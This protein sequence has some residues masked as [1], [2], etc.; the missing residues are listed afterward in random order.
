MRGKSEHRELRDEA[1]YEA[2]KKT[3]GDFPMLSFDEQ[4]QK[5][6]SARQPRMWVSFYGVY[7]MLLRIIAEKKTHYKKPLRAG[8]EKEIEM[9]YRRLQTSPYMKNASAY[10]IAS[11]IIAEPS[12]GFYVSHSYAKRIIFKTIHKKQQERHAT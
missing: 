11:F 5:T 4:I 6:L 12:A 7:R 8:L 2:Y 9:K 1:L 10:F 3:R